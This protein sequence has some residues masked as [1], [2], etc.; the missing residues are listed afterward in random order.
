MVSNDPLTGKTVV[1]EALEAR[2]RRVH[3]N[4]W[5]VKAKHVHSAAWEVGQEE[6]AAREI[7]VEAWE[8][9][10][11]AKKVS[12]AAQK[13]YRE[14]DKIRRLAVEKVRKV[15]RA[16]I[17]ILQAAYKE[18]GRGKSKEEL[19]A[20]DAK[21]AETRSMYYNRVMATETMPD[22]V[23]R[24]A[25]EEMEKLARE[26]VRKR[27]G[28]GKGHG[29]RRRKGRSWRSVVECIRMIGGRNGSGGMKMG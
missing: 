17:A 11:E 12:K 10:V 21:T 2:E 28:R 14:V 8:I 26:M 9:L 29:T 16:S 27:W 19:L 7:L 23:A 5:K 15:N 22:W 4:A 18:M 24:E 3:R 25:A 1:E 13:A 6:I 20:I